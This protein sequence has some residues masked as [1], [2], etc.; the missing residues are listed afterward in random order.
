MEVTDV[1]TQRIAAGPLDPKL[2]ELKEAT[3][4]VVG[5]VFLGTLLAQLRGSS[6]KGEYGHG[7]RGEEV[8]GAQL[9][10]IL[11]ERAGGSL[12]SGLGRVL[13]DHLAKQQCRLINSESSL[14]ESV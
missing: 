13:F 4:Q 9:D 2:R 14:K 10:G 12:E 8:F 6:L 1:D 11:A 7:G 5:R 3:D